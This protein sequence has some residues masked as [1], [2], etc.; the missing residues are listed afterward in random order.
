M[1]LTSALSHCRVL[2]LKKQM[3]ERWRRGQIRYDDEAAFEVAVEETAQG[4]LDK[5]LGS[6][7]RCVFI[8]F[9]SNF[10]AS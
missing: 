4:F 5:A 3:K 8:K 10:F 9:P 7:V 2:Q 6:E 1:Y